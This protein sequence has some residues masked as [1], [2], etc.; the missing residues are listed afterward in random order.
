MHRTHS[1]QR[2]DT[3]ETW[4]E[5]QRQD[6]NFV[7]KSAHLEATPVLTVNTIMTRKIELTLLL[8]GHTVD[9]R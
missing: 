1:D 5:G 2:P 9:E 8:D 6:Y 4:G 3:A 7:M